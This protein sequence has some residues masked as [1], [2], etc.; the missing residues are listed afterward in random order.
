MAAIR[1]KC[2]VSSVMMIRGATLP[3]CCLPLWPSRQR[4]VFLDN[5]FRVA[6]G[7]AVRVLYLGATENGVDNDVDE[8]KGSN[9]E[10][11]EGVNGD[12]I[13]VRG[14]R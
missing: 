9:A 1:N 4:G 13:G 6:N 8:V 7:R 12:T 10:Y 3:R 2:T 5:D 11:G 14:K